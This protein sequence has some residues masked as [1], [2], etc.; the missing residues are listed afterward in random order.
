VQAAALGERLLRVQ[1]HVDDVVRLAGG[2]E[3]LER[4]QDERAEA[5]QR[6]PA[7]RAAPAFGRGRGGRHTHLLGVHRVRGGQG[8]P[9]RACGC[10]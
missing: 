3:D 4:E 1:R 6:E 5:E 2:G 8:R 7:A 9:L 10:L